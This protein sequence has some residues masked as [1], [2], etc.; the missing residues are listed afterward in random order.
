MKALIFNSG[1]GSRM[2]KLTERC[3]KCLVKLPDG[4]TILSR[5][6]RILSELGISEA[7]ITTGKYTAE[8]RAEAEKCSSMNFTFVENPRYAETNYIYSMHLAVEYLDDDVLMLHGDL[9]FDRDAPGFMLSSQKD[10][11][12]I[13]EKTDS[14]P[15]KDFKCAVENGILRKVSVDIFGENCYAFQPIYKLSRKV[16]RQWADRVGEYVAI[17][18]TSVYAEEA[19]NDL[20]YAMTV[21]AVK[22]EKGFVREVDDEN[23]YLQVGYLA[24]LSDMGIFGNIRVLP[25]LIQK[26]QCTRPFVMVGRHCRSMAE[27]M[28]KKSVETECCFFSDYRENPD[29]ESIRR[30]AYI[31][32]MHKSDIIISI[33]G[34]SVIDTAKGVKALTGSDVSHIAVPTTAGSGSEATKFAVYYKNGKKQLFEAPGLMPASTV[35]DSSLLYTL[36]RTQ[37]M[38]TLLD[39]FCH[40][41]ESLLSVHANSES[42]MYAENSIRLINEYYGRYACGERVVYG[43]IAVASHYAGKAINISKTAAGH[44]MSYVLTSKYG[45]KHGQAA[46]VCLKYVLALLLEENRLPTDFQNIYRTLSDIYSAAEFEPMSCFAKVTANDMLCC[47]NAE[48]MK[49]FSLLLEEKEITEIYKRVIADLLGNC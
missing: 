16:F 21:H 40:S 25:E 19:L 38:T 43:M 33:G 4:E 49:N 30:A 2:G 17:G 20:L 28:L 44:A 46:A 37:R 41:A 42:R 34:G 5:Q 13:Y 11:M 6:L 35:V 3:P 27:E 22:A 9:V 23:D 15:V 45:I 14:L 29:E 32:R 36:D 31:F 10:D 1:T 7:V 12:C 18:K 26:L 8:I 24:F 39:A 47:V 48:R